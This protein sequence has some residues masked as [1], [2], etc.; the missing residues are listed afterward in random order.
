MRGQQRQQTGEQDQARDQRDR[1]ARQ[2]HAA[3]SDS[4]GGLCPLG[5]AVVAMAQGFQRAMEKLDDQNGSD[6]AQQNA[7]FQQMAMPDNAGRHDHGG[8]VA[9]QRAPSPA[10]V[11]LHQTH[12]AEGVEETLFSFSG[13]FN[14]ERNLFSRPETADNGMAGNP[15]GFAWTSSLTLMLEVP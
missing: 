3:Q 14:K 2:Q 1:Q 15:K 8:A 13:L 5:K 7:P 9:P 6:A 10:K 12:F 4:Q 11:F